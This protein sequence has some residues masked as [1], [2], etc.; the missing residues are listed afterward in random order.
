MQIG[1]IGLAG[2]ARESRGARARPAFR[3]F[4]YDK[5]RL[6]TRGACGRARPGVRREPR[7]LCARMEGE[8]VIVLS[9]RQARRSRQRFAS[10]CRCRHRRHVVDGGNQLL[11]RLD[12]TRARDV[13]EGPALHRRGYWAV[14]MVRTRLL[15]DARWNAQ[16]DRDLRAFARVLAPDAERGWRMRAQRRRHF[17]KMIHNGIRVRHHAVARGRFSLLARAPSSTSTRRASRKH[18]VTA[19]WCAPGCSILRRHPPPARAFLAH[20]ADRRRLGRRAWTALESIE[21]GVPAR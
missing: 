2:W 8:R 19:V 21:L 17:A 18:G 1:I 13:A 14:C 16:V 12:A 5:C 15:P 9:R 10:W 4:C 11:P 3:V 7:R 20:R 6:G